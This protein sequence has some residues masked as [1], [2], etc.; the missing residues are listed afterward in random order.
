M[1]F[2][3]LAGYLTPSLLGLAAAA[4]LGAGRIRL[5]LWIAIALLFL[6]LIVVRNLYGMMAVLVTGGVV[7]AISWYASPAAQ[8]AFAYTAVWFALMGG[9][10]PP[11][12]LARQRHRGRAPDS[13]VDQLAALTRVPGGLWLG[14]HMIATLAALA[15]GARMLGLIDQ[16]ASLAR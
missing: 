3:L 7:F 15:A 16:A 11:F 10:R 8:A 12:E 13:D 9:V 14:L 6:V 4:A 2:T 5:T 1:V